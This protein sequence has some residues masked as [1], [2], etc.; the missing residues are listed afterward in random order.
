MSSKGCGEESFGV[1]DVLEVELAN[2]E[3]KAMISKYVQDQRKE[4][5]KLH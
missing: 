3:T 5:L 4:Y 1:M 2:T